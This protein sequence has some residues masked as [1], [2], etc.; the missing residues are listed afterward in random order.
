MNQKIDVV[1]ERGFWISN[2]DWQHTFIEQLS[3]EINKY[4]NENSIRSVYDFGC[5]KGNYLQK[6]Y[7]MDS[8]INLIGFEGHQTEG[9][10]HNILRQDLSVPMEIEKADL[11]IS[12]EVGEHIPKEF[13]NIFLN[14]IS[15]NASKHVIMSW[16]IEGQ[17]GLGHI[18]CQNN[19]YI[20]YKMHDLGW[21]FN[22]EKSTDMRSRMPDN[23]IKHT[24]MVFEK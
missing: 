17:S 14:N 24:L 3:K 6:I 1:S 15:S 16:A 10:F 20:I 21:I 5:G 23:W 11:V 13:E 12:I 7:E 4:I 22:Q 9:V 19:D 18:N 8:S 2:Q